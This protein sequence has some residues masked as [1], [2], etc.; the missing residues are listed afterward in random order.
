M[1][2][3]RRERLHDKVGDA[4][5]KWVLVGVLGTE[6]EEVGVS[7]MALLSLLNNRGLVGGM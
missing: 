2:E 1:F 5:Q 4:G 3:A 7:R 6:G